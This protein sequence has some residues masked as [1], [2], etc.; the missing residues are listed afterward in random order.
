[1][2]EMIPGLIAINKFSSIVAYASQ[3]LSTLIG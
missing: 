2:L 3:K 1:M